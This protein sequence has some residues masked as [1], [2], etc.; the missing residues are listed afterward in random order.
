MQPS[1]TA[2]DVP[3]RRN[4]PLRIKTWLNLDSNHAGPMREKTKGSWEHFYNN[5]LF[6]ASEEKHVEQQRFIGYGTQGKRR[7]EGCGWCHN[8]TSNLLKQT[9]CRLDT[10]LFTVTMIK[11][12]LQ[13]YWTD[14]RQHTQTHT[15]RK[16]RNPNERSTFAARE[17]G[18][19]GYS[20]AQF[21]ITEFLCY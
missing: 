20:H 7:G 9:Q 10:R 12:L 11:D 2:K 18:G 15:H 17:G 5:Y 3:A 6:P 13:A 8:Y 19:W 21:Q 1:G 4:G 16:R 14:R